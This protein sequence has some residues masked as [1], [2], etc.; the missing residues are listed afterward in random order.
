[1]SKF[2]EGKWG[3]FESSNMGLLLVRTEANGE[4]Y[5]QQVGS[6]ADTHLIAA[7][8]DMYEAL[9]DV[10]ILLRWRGEGPLESM[11]N[12]CEKFYRDTGI[13]APGKSEPLEMAGRY[14]AKER[15]EAWDQWGLVKVDKAMAALAKA[16]G[17]A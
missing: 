4:S 17:E 5:K 8:P 10:L 2:T 12:M 16:R 11:E 9:E 6:A 14:S 15:V 7:A 1:M 13:M 3:V